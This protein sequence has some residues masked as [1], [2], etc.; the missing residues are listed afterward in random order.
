M[1]K[2]LKTSTRTV[3]PLTWT[4]N[5]TKE[6]TET[7]KNLHEA[8]SLCDSLN[9]LYETLSRLEFIIRKKNIKEGLK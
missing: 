1:S 4:I 3:Q 8:L 7:E 5:K 6:I 9:K 2:R